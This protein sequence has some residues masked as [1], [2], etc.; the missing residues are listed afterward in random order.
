MALAGGLGA[1][2]AAAEPR[3]G[4]TTYVLVHG[5]H[6]AGA[7]WMP[8][9]REL[10]LRGHRAVMVDQ[11]RHGAE[12]FVPDSYQRQDPAAMAVEPSPLKGLG[13]DD[14][15]ARVTGVVRR[16]ARY[17]SV[18]L[19]G[20]SLGGVSVSRVGN[21]VPH[22][23]QH[24]CYMAAFCPSRALPTADACTAAPEN[25][26]AVSPVEIMVGDPN[27]LGVLRLN[28]RT[29]DSRELALLK[30]MICA[31]YPEAEFRRLLAGMQTDEP[32]AAYA[33]RAVGR[34][35][36]WGRIPRTYLRF[37]KDRTIA[38]ALQDRMVAEADALTPGNRFRVHN[39]PDA[40]HVGPLGPASLAEALDK[41]A[42]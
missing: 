40:S 34:A 41:L 29:G 16:A 1:S 31:D 22:L 24:I 30:E 8:I 19:V 39:F 13:L 20:H 17:G 15:E 10:T 25:A 33:G 21:A 32:I 14:Y 18:V 7:F 26:N 4:P 38:T 5:T 6:S 23:L 36:S 37:G 27:R 28:F 9:A 35:D 42:A 12:A 11:P 3:H 2:R